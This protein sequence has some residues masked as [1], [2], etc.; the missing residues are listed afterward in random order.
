VP[1]IAPMQRLLDQFRAI[2]GNP[3]IGTI[4][5]TMKKTPLSLNNVLNRQIPSTYAKSAGDAELVH[6]DFGLAEHYGYAPTRDTC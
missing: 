1:V 5:A 4:F 2:R 6:Q 3:A